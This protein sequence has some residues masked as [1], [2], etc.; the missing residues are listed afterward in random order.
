M[1][2]QNKFVMGAML[3]G[4]ILATGVSAQRTHFRHPHPHPIIP[5]IPIRP[6]PVPNII[7]VQGV[8]ATVRIRGQ[9]ATTELLIRV[10]NEGRGRAEAQLIMPV[11]VGAAIRGFGFDG[12]NKEMT[13]QLLKR[14]EARRIYES[15]VRQMR[16]PALLEFIGHNLVKSSAFP[17]DPGKTQTLRLVYENLLKVRGNGM[18]YVLPRSESL[19]YKVPW[20]VSIDIRHDRPVAAVYSPSHGLVTKRQT[21][22]SLAV[23]VN[24]ASMS[25]PGPFRLHV[26]T[27]SR[28]GLTGTA[29]AYPDPKGKGGYFLMIV[30]LPSRIAKRKMLK[31]EITL[32]LDRSGSMRGEKIAQ[33]REAALQVVAGL[34]D[35]ETFNIITY[36]EDIDAFAKQPVIKSAK[37]M[38][39]VEEYLKGVRANGGTNIHAALLEALRPAPAKGVLPIILFLTDGLPTVGNTS[40]KAIREMARTKNAHNRRIFTFGVGLDVNTPLLDKI[41]M[42]TRATSTFVLPKEDVEVKVGRVFRNLAGPVFADLEFLPN[43][44][45]GVRRV[46]DVL[47]TKLPDL[48][49][50]GQLI[51][52]GRYIGEKPLDLMVSGNFLGAKRTV[53]VEVIPTDATTLNAFVPRLW[54]T[55]KIG[56]LEDQIREMGADGANAARDPRFR[57]LVDEI[58]RLS[59]EF[60]ILSEYTAFLAKEETKVASMPAVRDE[61]AHNFDKRS[62][63]ERSGKGS[64]AQEMNRAVRLK[65]EGMSRLNVYLDADM[66]VVRIR[67]VQQVNDLAFYR[68]GGRWID[69]RLLK[70]GD[71]QKADRNVAFGTKEY[72]KLVRR[73]EAQNRQGVLSMG[74]DV[75]VLVDG[76]S[77]YI[78][79]AK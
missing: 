18:D 59:T 5:I 46:V 54:A 61:A 33:A 19:D 13:A 38:K 4:L 75:L 43:A 1:C 74:G 42:E 24:A 51:L 78:A 30:G 50:G 52:L 64:V 3:L 20:T 23:T 27:E 63:R 17:L 12:V 66:E 6:M 26:Q 47:P 39:A 8:E 44:E 55:R 65:Q 45:G 14:E 49:E 35:G 41:A 67:T 57:E 36:N 31:R 7:K 69:S 73:L 29:Y 16:D 40:E 58:V 25:E 22:T 77:N 32:V 34:A 72:F 53:S 62:L 2:R 76:V 28:K 10:R 79:A 48:F 37:Q 60:G 68:R 71:K 11:P 9:M 21:A 70:R 15:I 56:I